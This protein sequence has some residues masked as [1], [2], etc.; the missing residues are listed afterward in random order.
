M[1]EMGVSGLVLEEVD[2]SSLQICITTGNH[3][4]ICSTRGGGGTR[5]SGISM[6]A[7]QKS[8]GTTGCKFPWN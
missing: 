7:S 6:A 8:S 1:L 5:M 3:A 2:V 4:Y